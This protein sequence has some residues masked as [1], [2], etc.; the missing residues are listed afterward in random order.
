MNQIVEIDTEFFCDGHYSVLL[1][2]SLGRSGID[3]HKLADMLGESDP[4]TLKD[5]LRRGIC[6]PIDF[7]TDGA[8]SDGSRFVIGELDAAHEKAWIGRL[9]GKLSIPCGKLVLLCG[10]GVGE[11]LARAVSGKAP[12]KDYVIYQTLDVPPGDY[13]VDVLAYVESPTV[14]LHHEDLDEDDI[15]DKYK[16]LPKVEDF[17]V[18]HL[19]PLKGDVPL[20]ALIE[21]AG[22]PGVFEFR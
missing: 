3:P 17:Y 14:M 11:D 21:D 12:D 10:G 16:H 7:G 6:L 8:L 15:R 5:L 2:Q 20:P 19:T 18:I 1:S 13:R 9:T 4:E 22:W